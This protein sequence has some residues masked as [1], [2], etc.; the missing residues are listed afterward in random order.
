MSPRRYAAKADA[1]VLLI[2]GK[3][4]TVVP[5]LH[6]YKMADALKDVGKPH[7]LVTLDGEGHWLSL[8]KTRLEMLEAAVGLVEKHNP[9]D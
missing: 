6:S 7:E 2:H 9:A 5:Y 8:S 1:P 4:D 3:D